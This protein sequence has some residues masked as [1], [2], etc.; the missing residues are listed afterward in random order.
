M[1]FGGTSMERSIWFDFASVTAK[2]TVP[3]DAASFTLPVWHSRRNVPATGH[4]NTTFSPSNFASNATAA[5]HAA[6]TAIVS[7][8]LMFHTFPLVTRH[9][10]SASSRALPFS[11]KL[12]SVGRPFV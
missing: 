5:P 1:K 7:T 4:S 2:S 10:P 3:S 9:F 12:K 6:T 11:G 8:L